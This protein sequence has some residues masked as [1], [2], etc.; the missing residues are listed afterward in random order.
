[1]I[2][3][4]IPIISPFSRLTSIK[5]YAIFYS[6]EKA[7]DS[8]YLEREE[9][10]SANQEGK[11]RASRISLR[12]EIRY[13]VRGYTSE[14]VDTV[15]NNISASGLAFNSNKYIPPQTPLML[16]IDILSRI[17][18]PIGRVAW[19]QSLPHSDRNSL[20]V[21]FLEMDPLEKHYLE[22]YIKMQTGRF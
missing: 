7:M 19:C 16:E 22:D 8:S 2:S 11:R 1:M 14:F 21:E 18:H 13:H 9:N 15:S 12:A 20:G 17:L 6:R 5:I 10:L 3:L 4:P